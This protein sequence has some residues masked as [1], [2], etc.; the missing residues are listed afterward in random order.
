MLHY[1]RDLSQL[2]PHMRV[3][4]HLHVKG[5]LPTST[6]TPSQ[7]SILFMLFSVI[8]TREKYGSFMLRT[9]ACI[10]LRIQNWIHLSLMN[11][12]FYPTVMAIVDSGWFTK[13]N[14]YFVFSTFQMLQCY[15]ILG[16]AWQDQGSF[17]ETFFLRFHLSTRFVHVLCL[18][19]RGT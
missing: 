10:V 2:R 3:R 12:G 9:Y 1:T 17:R 6:K 14:C 5:T 13:R 18:F 19:P 11:I 15:L 8:R 4:T 7:I 16:T